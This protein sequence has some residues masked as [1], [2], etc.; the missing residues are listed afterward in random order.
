MAPPK[1]KLA[2]HL[3]ALVGNGRVVVTET[4]DGLSIYQLNGVEASTVLPLL[5]PDVW[6]AISVS[7]E[8]GELSQSDI[9]PTLEAVRITARREPLPEGVDAV[10]T[11]QAFKKLLS[12]KPAATCVWV[13]GLDEVIDT[14][15]VRYAPWGTTD[16]FEPFADAI[17]PAKVVRFLNPAD[18]SRGYLGRF[19]LRNSD[20]K[21]VPE[22]MA[23]WR[24]KA[25]IT[26][27]TALAQEV[28]PDGRL[29][30]RGPP[31]TRF[32]STP[33][34]GISKELFTAIQD[35]AKWVYGNDR[36]VDNRH[37]LMAAEIART[38]ET[39]GSLTELAE[40][41]SLSLE[42]AKIAYSFGLN[43]QSKDTLKALSD[44]RKAVTDEA[45]KVSD[46][47]RSL[48]GAVVGAVV[49]NVGLLIA[50]TSL[51]PNG[52]FVGP[53]A[54]LLGIVLA[55]YV[56]AVI[57]SG[58]QYINIQRQLRAQWRDKLYRFL[59]ATEYTEMVERPV[60]RAE[61][62]FYVVSVIGVMMAGLSLVAATEIAA[63]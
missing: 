45:S 24:Q 39:G 6:Q 1:A 21:T 17:D 40:G 33:D 49:G 42:G 43:Q 53:A 51:P 50:R 13:T 46:S 52:R 22:R 14:D 23:V 56:L 32:K 58:V 57:C 61:K 48:C 10:I 31:P 11:E 5:E 28:E 9:P 63:P 36:E 15:T 4:R 54:L 19:L 38:S 62:A 7:D 47:T 30:F 29:L 27:V 3:N 37:A 35:A 55:L 41:L 8:G 34:Q 44:L 20:Q 59:S 16:V 60:K 2:D 18:E 25:C 26:L 12:R